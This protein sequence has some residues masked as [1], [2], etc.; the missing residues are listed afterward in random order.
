MAITRLQH[1]LTSLVATKAHHQHKQGE[2]L[3]RCHRWA[4]LL[5]ERRPDSKV[6][7]EWAASQDNPANPANLDSP[8]NLDSR[9]LDLPK[10]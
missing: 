3:E 8:V 9:L 2:Q 6:P 7:L 10:S 5:A 1:F 4:V